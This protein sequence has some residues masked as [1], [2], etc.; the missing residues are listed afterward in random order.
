MFNVGLTEILVVALVSIIV[1]DKE[2]VPMFID[3]IRIV[4]KYILKI[5]FKAKKLLQDAGIEDL[6]TV[7]KGDY[8]TGKDG[9]LYHAYNIEGKNNDSKNSSSR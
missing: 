1:V 3:C 2:K 5:Q 9:K 6:Y 7:E 4:Y 8:I